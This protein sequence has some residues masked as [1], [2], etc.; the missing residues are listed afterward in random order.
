MLLDPAS[1]DNCLLVNKT[2]YGFVTSHILQNP[3][4]QRLVEDKQVGS[5]WFQRTPRIKELNL[6]PNATVQST[7]QDDEQLFIITKS[8]SP[9]HYGL[10]IFNGCGSLIHAMDITDNFDLLSSSVERNLKLIFTP[11]KILVDCNSS[12]LLIDRKTYERT[13]LSIPE[14]SHSYY[15]MYGD[16]ASANSAFYFLAVEHVCHYIFTG[17]EL[18][19]AM[20][21][22]WEISFRTRLPLPIPR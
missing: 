1:L 16:I 15:G 10:S 14:K 20:M 4:L 21:S 17:D 13:E 6:K 9:L 2:W 12:A 7:W 19:V 8:V 22:D 18:T 5:T 3:K 11:N